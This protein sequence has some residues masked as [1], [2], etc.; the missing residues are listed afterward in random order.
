M[1]LGYVKRA[2]LAAPTVSMAVALVSGLVAIV[3]LSLTIVHL[4]RWAFPA[5]DATA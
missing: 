1:K 4:L 2:V 5:V 3:L